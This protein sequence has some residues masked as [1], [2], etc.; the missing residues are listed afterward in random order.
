MIQV[1]T[2]D[3][4]TKVDTGL[5]T[6]TLQYHHARTDVGRRSA[7]P[8][9]CLQPQQEKCVIELRTRDRRHLPGGGNLEM[10]TESL[11]MK[12]MTIR[13]DQIPAYVQICWRR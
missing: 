2:K 4:P 12:M 7:H 5:F 1:H 3:R 8:L 6:E 9:S 11:I 10:L 13:I